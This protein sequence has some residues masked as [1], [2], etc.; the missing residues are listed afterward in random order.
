MRALS[1]FEIQAGWDIPAV[2]EQDI[3][4]DLPG[5]IRALVR[6]TVYDTA[7]GQYLLVPQGSRLVGTYDSKVAYAQNALLVV[8]NRIIFPDG[9]GGDGESGRAGAERPE[10]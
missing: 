1:P 3:N 8:W 4:S 6:E 5:E 7:S 9:S 10:G 2:L